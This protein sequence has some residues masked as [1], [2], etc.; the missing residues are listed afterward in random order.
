MTEQQDEFGDLREHLARVTNRSDEL[1][2]TVR[3]YKVKHDTLQQQ[4]EALQANY[5][6]VCTDLERAAGANKSL[7][8][9]N[10]RLTGLI[11]GIGHAVSS[12]IKGIRA[13]RPGDLRGVPTRSDDTEPLPRVVQMGPRT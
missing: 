1:V 2:A 3:D 10:V 4:F 6:R 5:E 9:E 7:F 8:N 13:L 12:G 11:T